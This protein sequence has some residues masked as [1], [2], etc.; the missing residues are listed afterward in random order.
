MTRILRLALGD[1]RNHA[2]AQLVVTGT[3]VAITGE[4]GAGKTNILEALS[5]LA[6][7]RGLRGA[8]LADIARQGGP[9]GWSV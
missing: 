2:A 4:N 3:F 9:G 6:P 5:L 8:A 7:G 1:F